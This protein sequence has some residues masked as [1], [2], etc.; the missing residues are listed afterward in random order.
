MAMSQGSLQCGP[1]NDLPK[2][3]L[4][5]SRVMLSSKPCNVTGTIKLIQL[6]F[7]KYPRINRAVA[8]DGE[9]ELQVFDA[10]PL[11]VNE[12]RQK[13]T[14]RQKASFSISQFR[15]GPFNKILTCPLRVPVPIHRGQYVAIAIP[16]DQDGRLNISSRSTNEA[17]K[18][19]IYYGKDV[20]TRIGNSIAYVGYKGSDTRGHSCSG[21]RVSVISGHTNRMQQQQGFSS[22]N[23][24]QSSTNSNN[25]D[26]ND[27]AGGVYLFGNIATTAEW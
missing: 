13:F 4:W 17:E 10:I 14:L 8:N 26:N 25:S 9:L 15:N 2:A 3:A 22:S 7:G 11:P 5:G 24:T 20:C 6:T 27:N 12:R 21:F 1:S 19:V 18:Q 16:R 23:T